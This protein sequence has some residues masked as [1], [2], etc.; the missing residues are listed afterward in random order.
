MGKYQAGSGV[1][2]DTA[3][4]EARALYGGNLNQGFLFKG[5]EYNA[6]TAMPM[7]WSMSAGNNKM[8]NNQNKIKSQGIT[9]SK[10]F[11]GQATKFGDSSE[12]RISTQ[13]VSAL[14]NDPTS[15]ILSREKVG[16][17]VAKPM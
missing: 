4:N 8:P 2:F 6:G 9:K 15:N 12:P 1:D 16:T 13:E 11:T 10:G 17:A 14:Q 5:Q 7:D 3:L